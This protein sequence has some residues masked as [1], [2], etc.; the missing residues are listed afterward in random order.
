MYDLRQRQVS[1]RA[2]SSADG[3]FDGT[4]EDVEF[5]LNPA[6]IGLGAHTINIRFQDDQGAWGEVVSQTITGSDTSE[7]ES[8]LITAA[9]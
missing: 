3:S 7:H 2:S 8:P 4:L 9:E 5:D 6:D 1:R